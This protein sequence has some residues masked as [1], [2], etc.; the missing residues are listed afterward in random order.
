MVS[1][2][3][4]VERK[5]ELLSLIM[6]KSRASDFVTFGSS[7][8]YDKYYGL[9]DLNVDIFPH[10][11]GGGKPNVSLSAQLC[12]DKNSFQVSDNCYLAV[13]SCSS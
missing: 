10:R 2:T 11:V 8:Y 6:A 3:H 9:G 5:T 1:T 4:V 7:G 12:S 13:S